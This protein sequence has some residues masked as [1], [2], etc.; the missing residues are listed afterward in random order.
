MVAKARWR[1]FVGT[2]FCGALTT[3]STFQVQ[4]VEFGD[5]GHVPLAA[6]YLAVS[7]AGRPR[8]RDGG[9]KA[10]APMIAWVAMTLAGSLG[11]YLRWQ[12]ARLLAPRG[13]LFV[14]LT[15]AFAAGV[16]AGRGC[17]HDRAADRRHRLPRRLHDVLDLDGRAHVPRHLDRRRAGRRDRR[18]RARLAVLDGSRVSRLVE[19]QLAAAR[20][21]QR[22]Q[23]PQPWSLHRRA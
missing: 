7:V 22:G 13:T 1:P 2:G 8:G 14:N 4:L 5:D 20:D 17:R 23:R 18:L 11:A 15:G 9:S 12:A 3:F 21:P 6:A 19:P 10:G 16:V